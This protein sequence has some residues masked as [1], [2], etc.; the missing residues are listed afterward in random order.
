MTDAAS[1]ASPVGVAVT[2]LPIEEALPELRAVLSRA[3][4][5]SGRAV[6]IAPPGAGKTT[7]V[8]PSLLG[9]T[10]C[11]GEIWIAAPRRVAVRA[12]AERMA[13]N[14]GEPVGRTVGYTTR[15]DS[16]TSP[17]TRIIAMTEAILVNRIVADPELAGVSA[18]LFDEAHERS[19]DSDVALAL[20]LDTANVLREDLRLVVMSATIEGSRF[21]ELLGGDV[22]VVTSHGRSHALDIRWARSH[23]LPDTVRACCDAALS[24]WRQ[25]EGDLLVFLPGVREIEDACELLRDRLPDASIIPL[26]GRI[27]ARG[28]RLA[29]QKDRA[30]RRIVV[31]SAIAETS[32]T[33]DGVRIVVDSGWSREARF[34]PLTG[35][36]RLQTVRS[37]QATATQR[38]GRAARQGP[39]VAYRL[40]E[41]AGH[42]GRPAFAEPEI[43]HADLA[44]L[45]MSLARWGTQDAASLRW[46]DPPPAASLVSAEDRLFDLGALS[47]GRLTDLGRRIAELPMHPQD[48][49]ALVFGA[50]NGCALEV[51]RLVVLMQE[52]GPGGS[53]ED[54]QVRE[55]RWHAAGGAAS[56]AKRWAGMVASDTA[57]G[58]LGAAQCLALSRTGNLARRRD[59]D[60]ERWHSVS[61]RGFVLDR[62]SSLARAE[63]LL[64]CDAQGRAGG[65][66]ITA[67]VALDEAE[68]EAAFASRIVRQ[69]DI[70]WNERAGRV[71]AVD[72][73]RLGAI[74]LHSGQAANVPADA[75]AAV[76]AKVVLDRLDQWLPADLM[77]RARFAGVDTLTRRNLEDCA[78]RWL[79]P[80][81]HG[82]RDPDVPTGQ[83]REAVMSMLDWDTRQS[84][85]RLAPPM[86]RSP[87]GTTHPID[88]TGDDAPSVE[89][90]VQAM[91]GCDAHPMVGADPLLLK[92]TSPASRPVQATRDLPAFWR[93]SW[94]D[95]RKEMKGRYPKHR[96]PEEPWLAAP[97]LKTKNAFEKGARTP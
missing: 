2:E 90:R 27:D 24:A 36:T 1:R 68:V 3:G 5:G 83:R 74:V 26:H 56:L 72:E 30:N 14:L 96:W 11:S 69:T 92:L 8:A 79:L 61:G 78:D 12:A 62:A 80:I 73:R 77:A 91:F 15:L 71:E 60:G 97:G 17:T 67:A 85:D 87:G 93:G 13:R 39:G 58:T 52:R 37:S 48:A 21:A 70:R 66:R 4:P 20:A 7:T 95:V 63:W 16:R 40:W 32:L 81:L 28:Q 29:L 9:E 59:R 89:V 53:G 19:L 75:I 10:W 84:L 22:P 57:D 55:R 6:L 31:A 33:L 76:L 42:A 65:A 43:A 82:R 25:E 45:R 64:V 44:P 34:D 94:A 47:E 51:A 35:T 18:I 23:R 46:L 54:L 41:E 49:A 86:F 88:Y 38:A 50:R